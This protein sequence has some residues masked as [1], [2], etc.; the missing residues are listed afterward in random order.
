MFMTHELVEI[1]RNNRCL[2]CRIVFLESSFSNPRPLICGS[3]RAHSAAIA[4]RGPQNSVW[5][6]PAHM[7]SAVPQSQHPGP[8]IHPGKESHLV[9][10]WRFSSLQSQKGSIHFGGFCKFRWESMFGKEK[11]QL[12][13]TSP[14]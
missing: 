1:P 11:G 6:C 2:V 13:Q 12:A 14:L 7:H 5:P 10:K 8:P 9:S 3:P 4:Q